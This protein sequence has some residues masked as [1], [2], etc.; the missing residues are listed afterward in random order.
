MEAVSA[1]KDGTVPLNSAQQNGQI[2]I[3]FTQEVT[4]LGERHQSGETVS[5]KMAMEIQN[6]GL[7][8]RGAQM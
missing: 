2:V 3:K 7:M 5:G 1:K 4:L 6:E 8:R